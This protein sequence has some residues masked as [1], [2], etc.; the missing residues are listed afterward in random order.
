MSCVDFASTT[1]Q[2]HIAPPH[3]ARNVKDRIRIA[4]RKLGWSFSRTKD[5]WYA[6]PRVSIDA[7]EM[8][9]IEEAA[10][11][12]NARKELHEL[13]MLIERAGALLDDEEKDRSRPFVDALRALVGTS[14]RS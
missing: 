8:R 5:V 9:V 11:L 13:E 4:S 6:D 14:D 3:A 1:L 7:E 10:G 12:K 2:K